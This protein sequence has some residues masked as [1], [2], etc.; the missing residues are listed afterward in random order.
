[1]FM[2]KCS[3]IAA[4]PS[5]GESHGRG[6]AGKTIISGENPREE[7]ENINGSETEMARGMNR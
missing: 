7:R 5:S 1:M 2:H 4:D 3:T 6:G